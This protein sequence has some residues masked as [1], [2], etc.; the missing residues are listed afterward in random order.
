ME[1][2]LSLHPSDVWLLEC[3]FSFKYAHNDFEKEFYLD[4]YLATWQIHQRGDLELR[5]CSF[6]FS[7]NLC[8]GISSRAEKK[9]DSKIQILV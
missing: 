2:N 4:G 8:I 6:C 7:Q 1:K 5:G 9:L 3:T